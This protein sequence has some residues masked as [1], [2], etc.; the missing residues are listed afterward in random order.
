MLG[1]QVTGEYTG[2]WGRILPGPPQPMV[3]R[4]LQM[5]EIQLGQPLPLPIRSQASQWASCSG[6]GMEEHPPGCGQG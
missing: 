1:K 6:K 3:G 2:E 5:P 4:S